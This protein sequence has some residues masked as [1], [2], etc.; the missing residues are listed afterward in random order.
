[1]QRSNINT[2]NALFERLK[3][4]NEKKLWREDTSN[5]NKRKD[6]QK[7]KYRRE[8]ERER[9]R[10]SSRRVNCNRQI[11]DRSTSPIAII[12]RLIAG[13]PHTA[14]FTSPSATYSGFS[15]TPFL[16]FQPSRMPLPLLLHV[17]S[18]ASVPL[19]SH[20]KVQS[21]FRFS[22]TWQTTNGKINIPRME[23][24]K[25]QTQINKYVT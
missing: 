13:Y 3:R 22:D 17:A 10:M 5:T 1:M 2:E 4:T 20:V 23:M 15:P 18:F 8:R 25:R 14:G 11:L 24:C 12:S 9:G 19:Q 7:C 21:L 6:V 16:H